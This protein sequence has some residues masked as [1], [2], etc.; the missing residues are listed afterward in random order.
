MN[1]VMP[2]QSTISLTQ[3]NKR[4]QQCNQLCFTTLHCLIEETTGVSTCTNIL[5]WN[6]RK[7][8]ISSVFPGY[9]GVYECNILTNNYHV[10]TENVV[11]GDPS[12]SVK[13]KQ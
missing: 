7:Y 1:H 3:V 6:I 5:T 8:I 10:I 2:L 9:G 4:L 11:S 12:H 13:K